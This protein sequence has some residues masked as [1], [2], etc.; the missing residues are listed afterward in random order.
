MTPARL[1]TGIL[2]LAGGLVVAIAAFFFY[3]RWQGRRLGHDVPTG[4][5][6]SIQ[7]STEGFTHS[8]SRGGHTIY[9][10]HASKGCSSRVTATQS[11][12]T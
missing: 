12:T 3:G 5:G 2:V 11:C 6:T 9:T 1:R 8:E 7:Q 10:L 4:L